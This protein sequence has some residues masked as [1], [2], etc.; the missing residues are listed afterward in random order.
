MIK[1]CLAAIID[2]GVSR[3]LHDITAILLDV[4]TLPGQCIDHAIRQRRLLRRSVATA[5][6]TVVTVPKKKKRKP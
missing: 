4:Q 5:A 6:R 1:T 2:E 3:V